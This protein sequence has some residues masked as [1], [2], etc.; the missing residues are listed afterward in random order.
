MQ[1]SHLILK[2]LSLSGRGFRMHLCMGFRP[3]PPNEYPRYDT[4]QSDDQALVMQEYS[5]IVITPRSTLTRIDST[6]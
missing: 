6:W 1:K 2:I 3:R 4:K 5:S